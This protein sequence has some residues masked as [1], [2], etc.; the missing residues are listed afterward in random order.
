MDYDVDIDGRYFCVTIEEN[1]IDVYSTT[2]VSK[3]CSPV[4]KT[5][6]SVVILVAGMFVVI[7]LY[8]KKVE[9]IKDVYR[10][11]EYVAKDIYKKAIVKVWVANNP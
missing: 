7:D 8:N 11:A 5:I 9:D 2:G 1:K 6:H 3:D 4:F 10:N